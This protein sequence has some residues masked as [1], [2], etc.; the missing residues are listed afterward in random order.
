MI[1]A[2]YDAKKCDDYKDKY[3]YWKTPYDAASN[4]TVNLSDPTIT[5]SDPGNAL[6]FDD[7]H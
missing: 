6:A 4:T 1:P 5:N 3:P 2:G 7:A